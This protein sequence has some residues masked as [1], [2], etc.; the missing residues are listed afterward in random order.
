MGRSGA[1]TLALSL[2]GH[3]SGDVDV[4][5]V[6]DCSYVG[7]TAEAILLGDADHAVFTVELA[8]TG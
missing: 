2:S 6:V 4:I 3:L 7:H 8:L 1:E 5:T